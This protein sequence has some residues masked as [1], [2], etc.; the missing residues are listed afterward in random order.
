MISC[1]VSKFE[2]APDG[3]WH[4]IETCVVGESLMLGRGSG[5]EIHLPDR[6]VELQHATLSRQPDGELRIE[7]VPGALI[8]VDGFLDRAYAVGQGSVIGVG[9]YRLTIGAGSSGHDL[10]ILVE[11]PAGEFPLAATVGATPARSV[12]AG[13]GL[14]RQAAGLGV[15]VVLLFLVLPLLPR[16]SPAL[17]E[18]QSRLP[19]TFTDAVSPGPLSPGHAAIERRCSACHQ[20]A[21]QAVADSTC[22]ECHA[23]LA[24]HLPRNALNADLS[25]SVRCAECHAA[26]EGKRGATGRRSSTCVA[27]HQQLDAGVSRFVDF[28]TDHPGFRLTVPTGKTERRF[29]PGVEEA[30]RELSGL[31]FSH[32]VHLDKAGVA[33]PT[34][35]TVLGCADCHVLEAAGERFAPIEM[36]Q[37]CQ[38]SRCHR[39]RYSGPVRSLVPHGAEA[40]VINAL[41][42]HYANWL[43]DTP[44][45]GWDCPSSVAPAKLARRL[46]DCADDLARRNAEASL[47][48]RT[49]KNLECGLCHEIAET[50]SAGLPWKVEKPRARQDWQPKARFPHDRHGT[51]AC[52]DCH[53]KEGSRSSED[54][55]FPSIARCR[56]CHAGDRP[57]PGKVASPCQACHRFHRVAPD[58]GE[59]EARA[60]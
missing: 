50:G 27:C 41:R 1:L 48:R 30:P 23:K 39:I 45:T 7:A 21:F 55:S 52:V 5:C 29:E 6:R 3:T 59:A 38:Q 11:L 42:I 25:G 35:D 51:V 4:R 44:P 43:A 22:T 60:R 16:V 2:P 40:E 28:A 56:E 57:G 58:L 54:F 34:G 47:F 18:W 19:L 46:L 31:K 49:G 14:R 37:T 15:L 12:G 24:R 20:K 9:P 26:H 33:S 53:D 13:R 10:Q 17:D 32:R 36:E 8:S